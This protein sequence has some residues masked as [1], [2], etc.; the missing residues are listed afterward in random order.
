[1][2]DRLFGNERE[3]RD[4]LESFLAPHCRLIPEV[5]LR[6][7][8]TQQLLRIDYVAIFRRFRRNSTEPT[9]IGVECK[10]AF[11]DFRD[12]TAALKQGIDYRHAVVVDRRAVVY[13]GATLAFV[14]VWPD[15]RDLGDLAEHKPERVRWAEG[16]ERLA[17]KFNVGSVRWRRDPIDLF[18]DDY[19]ELTCA[20]DPLWNTRTGPRWGD[21]WG[22]GRHPGAA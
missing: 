16:A 17:G 5:W 7:G 13:Q 20:A 9:L 15:L 10:A 11:E 4:F 6:H 3:A 12:W 1:M 14:F 2:T 21:G 8:V 18:A 19:L 22:T